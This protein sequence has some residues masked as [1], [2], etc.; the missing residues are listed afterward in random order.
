MSNK[1]AARKFARNLSGFA[2]IKY[3]APDSHSVFYCGG[4]PHT[5]EQ[6]DSGTDTTV[7]RFNHLIISNSQSVRSGVYYY[8]TNTQIDTTTTT[9]IKTLVCCA[10]PVQQVGQSPA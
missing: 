4:A 9:H 2:R 8:L 5:F 10:R 3:Y 7:F 1:R 6:E